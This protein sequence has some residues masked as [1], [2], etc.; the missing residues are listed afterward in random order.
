MESLSTYAH[1]FLERLDRPDVDRIERID[2]PPRV[3][4]G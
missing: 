1:M 3:Q 2:P 4:R